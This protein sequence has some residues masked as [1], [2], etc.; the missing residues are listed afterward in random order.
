M[1]IL[2]HAVLPS[3]SIR[4]VL[5]HVGSVQVAFV[6][7]QLSLLPS[8][9]SCSARSRLTFVETRWEHDPAWAIT[10]KLLI[11]KHQQVQLLEAASV[12]VHMNQDGVPADG[13]EVESEFSSA[14]PDASSELRNGLSSVET[15]PPP[16]EDQE[17]GTSAN[18]GKRVSVGNASAFS[19]SYQSVPSSSFTGSAPMHSPVFSHFR[20]P[21]I[22]TRPST[23]ETKLHDDDEADLAAA[24]GLCNFGTPRTGPVSVSPSVP[25]VPPLPSRFLDQS[26]SGDQS[27]SL[28][29][30][31]AGESETG[32]ANSARSSL[33]PMRC[34]PSLSYKVSDERGTRM[35]DADRA[36][37]Q[38]R[39]AD[40]DF[41]GR[42]A[43]VDEDDD[44]DGVFGRMEE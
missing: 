5:R 35:G 9:L 1:C 21:S 32:F 11:S 43:P 22:D 23:A 27:Y 16:L 19:R 28:E 31:R 20:H 17:N 40:V 42:A 38:N 12:L 13:P 24:I 6:A 37:R 15:T 8:S 25:P 33:L 29:Q 44:V 14:S 7:I 10:S 3:G 41:S 26:G 36:S 2:P 4:S 39:N 30:L 34:D 18:M